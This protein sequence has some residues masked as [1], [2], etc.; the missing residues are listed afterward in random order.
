MDKISSSRTEITTQR[1]RSSAGALSREAILGQLEKILASPMFAR[2]QRLDRFLRLTAEMTLNRQANDIKEYLLGVEVFD[3]GESYD[4]RIDPIVRVEAR[5]LRDKLEEYYKGE[6]RDDPIRIRLPK[7]TYV[8]TFEIG[9]KL[10]QPDIAQHGAIATPNTRKAVSVLLV[11]LAIGG[12]A[13][14]AAH[15]LPFWTEPTAATPSVFTIAVLPLENLSGD[16]EQE[17]L[18]DGLTEALITELSK[19][20][21]FRVKSRTTTMQ[22]K[23]A[24]RSLSEI[25]RELQADA[26]VEGGV[27]GAGPTVHLKARLVDGASD[28]KLWAGSFDGKME[29][30]VGVQANAAH[31]IADAIQRRYGSPAARRR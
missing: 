14:L 15:Y 5:R 8:P 7:G 17:H 2:S 16:P 10:P 18:A 6:G 24:R 25:A 11:V 19:I 20:G 27:V 21:G 28:T 26:L 9:T 1:T 3:R 4:P 31:L 30:L 23:G 13:Y 22:Y 12:A 29:E